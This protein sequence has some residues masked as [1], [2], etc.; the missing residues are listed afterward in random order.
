MF[1]GF[2]DAAYG[3][4]HTTDNT[5]LA[6]PADGGEATIHIKPMLNSID[7]ETEQPTYRLFTKDIIVD[8]EEAEEF[9]EWLTINI[10]NEDYKEDSEHYAE[11]DLIV[12]AEALPA[13]VKGR[14]AE[15]TFFQE[16]ALLKVSVLQGEDAS[17]ISQTKVATSVSN[18]KLYDL[19]G[20]QVKAGKKGLILS[21]GKKFIVK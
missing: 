11:Y 21:N 3:Y 20:R 15:I 4:L 17:G 1:L 6:L 12:K 19:N 13:E 9:P 7:N 10:A 8:G 16:G 2:I 5:D 18:G 14:K